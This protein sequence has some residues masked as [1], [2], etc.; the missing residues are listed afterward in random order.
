[1]NR[2]FGTATIARIA[3]VRSTCRAGID[4]TPTRRLR[5]RVARVAGSAAWT[6]TRTTNS[7]GRASKEWVFVFNKCAY[8]PPLT[9]ENEMEMMLNVKA[10]DADAR[11]FMIVRNMRLV[12][13]CASKYV[14]RWYDMDE[15]VSIGTIGLIKAVDSFN[16]D[17]G[18]RFSTF[19]SRCINNQILMFL[20]KEKRY[21]SNT[22]SL[23]A[24]LYDDGEGNEARY[25]RCLGTDADLVSR[26][27]ERKEESAMLRCSLLC[28][29]ETQRRIIGLRYGADSSTQAEVAECMG[30]SQS[31]VSRLERRAIGSLR[32]EMRRMSVTKTEV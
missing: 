8:P 32:E 24:F 28:L 19:A 27:I 30:L 14:S 23:D 25:D 17:L 13:L 20:R 16:P 22:I 7:G 4:V 11:T 5:I 10:G 2:A 21:M 26:S 3:A 9:R 18:Y 12:V 6:T 29:N 15:L 1:M 31:Y